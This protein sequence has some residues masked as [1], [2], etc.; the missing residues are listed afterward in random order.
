MFPGV[1]VVFGVT[2]PG[3]VVALPGA[4]L[5]P[6]VALPV[7]PVVP[8]VP[9]VPEEP[10]VPGAWVVVE[11]VLLGIVLPGV[12]LLVPGVCVGEA[13][14]VEPGVAEGEVVL[15]CPLGAVPAAP[16]APA[17]CPGAALPAPTDEPDEPDV[18]PI[19]AAISTVP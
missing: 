15:V 5:L 11:P 2:V 14:V 4:V 13:P 3:V 10:A 6:G 8:V 16:V 19:N 7:L 12:V 1:F 17:V 18:C 9:V